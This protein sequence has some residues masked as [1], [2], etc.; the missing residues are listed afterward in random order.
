MSGE[1]ENWNDDAFS[2]PFPPQ[3]PFLGER[4]SLSSRVEI[5][6]FFSLASESEN[7]CDTT[8]LHTLPLVF[9]T[10][11]DYQIRSRGGRVTEGKVR[12]ERR[13]PIMTG[14]READTACRL[15][16]LTAS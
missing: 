9:H 11:T 2:I 10:M 5:D 1:K 6:I 4:E 14:M 3:D 7:V 12:R 8:I 16:C 15:V 13:S